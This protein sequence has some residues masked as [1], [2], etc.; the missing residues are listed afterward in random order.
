MKREEW[1]IFSWAS[2][3]EIKNG[4]D[5]KAVANENGKYPIYGSGG[6]MGYADAYICPEDTT[7]IGRKGS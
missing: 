2:V 1:E 4:K 6:K 3:L 7:I 5:Y